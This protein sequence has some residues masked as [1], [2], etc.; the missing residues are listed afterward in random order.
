MASTVKGKMAVT[1]SGVEVV[2]DSGSGTKVQKHELS[3]LIDLANGTSAGQIDLAYSETKTGVAA[4]TTTVYDLAGSLTDLAGDT[5]AFAEVVLI[6]IRNRS[7]TA[8]NR[9]HIGPDATN[10]FGVEASNLGFWADASDRS[11]VAAD[12]D[13]DANDGSWC[14]MHCRSGVA[15]SGGSTDELAV[16]T[17]SGSSSNT[18]DIVILGRSA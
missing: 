15:V 7:T 3:W 14:I 2:T 17:Q 1:I 9:I 6:A 11:V 18:W 13:S 5:I 12:F 16:I 4:S 10:G 8:V